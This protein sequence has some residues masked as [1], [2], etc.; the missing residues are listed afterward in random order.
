MFVTLYYIYTPYQPIKLTKITKNYPRH[1]YD[2]LWRLPRTNNTSPMWLLRNWRRSYSKKDLRA[3]L[4]TM[5]KVDNPALST[6][7]L[8]RS[9]ASCSRI[10]EMFS[11]FTW[12]CGHI[13]IF[14]RLFLPYSPWVILIYSIVILNCHCIGHCNVGCMY[15]VHSFLLVRDQTIYVFGFLLCANILWPTDTSAPFLMYFPCN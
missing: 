10:W 7:L 6:F 3:N 11:Q 1:N 2:E 4:R 12:V 14:L 9:K 5:L 8:Y 13:V 15:D